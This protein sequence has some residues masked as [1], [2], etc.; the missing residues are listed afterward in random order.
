MIK[1]FSVGS[2][3]VHGEAIDK[4]RY[5]QSQEDRDANRNPYSYTWMSVRPPSNTAGVLL[6]LAITRDILRD[7]DKQRERWKNTE[8]RDI[9]I[10]THRKK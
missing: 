1:A 8:R 5:D 9:Q 7:E 2:N 10:L 3:S 6:Y 4:E